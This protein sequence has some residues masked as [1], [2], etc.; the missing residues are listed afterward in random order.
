MCVFPPGLA[1][2]YNT[3][4][5]FLLTK[6][7]TLYSLDHYIFKRNISRKHKI[8]FYTFSQL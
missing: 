2:I 1:T 7:E 5:I 4:L 8:K 3:E 6:V